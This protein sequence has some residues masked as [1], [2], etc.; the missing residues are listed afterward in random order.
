MTEA[1]PRSPD[2][3]GLITMPKQESSPT[4]PTANIAATGVNSTAETGPKSLE[5]QLV[6]KDKIIED[7]T[8]QLAEAQKTIEAVR[9]ECIID[10][11]TGLHNNRYLTDY[12]ENFDKART[13][14]PVIVIFCDADNLGAFN[15]INGDKAGDQ[16]L[17][18]IATSIKDS[19]RKEDTVVR[20]GGDEFVIIIEDYSDFQETKDKVSE[21]LQS[22]QTPDNNIHFSFGIAQYDP[23]QD[24]S[25]RDTIQRGDNQMKENNPVK[26]IPKK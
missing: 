19:V 21:R 25:L 26:R 8:R 12:I 3:S 15:K 2:Q 4:I 7:L 14:K 11:L 5:E 16:L 9:K 18:N 10:S 17:I 20:K 24:K 23:E 22:K 1:I 13:K 6:E